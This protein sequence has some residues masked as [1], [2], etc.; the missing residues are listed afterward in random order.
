MRRASLG[1]GGGAAGGFARPSPIHDYLYHGPRGAITPTG[2]LVL[3]TAP[4]RER[5]FED[6]AEPP[7]AGYPHALLA[8]GRAASATSMM[9]GMGGMGGGMALNQLLIVM[10]GIDDPPLRKRFSDEPRQHAA[11]RALHRPAARRQGAPAAASRRSPPTRRST[12][13]APATS[14]SRRSTRRSRARAAWAGTSASARRSRTT[15]RT[16]SSFYLDKVSHEPDLDT[17]RRRDELARITGGYSPGDDRAGLLDGAHV[18]PPR[19]ARALRLGRH[20]RGHDDGRDGHRGRRRVRRAR[21]RGR[22][23]STRRATPPPATST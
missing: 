19:R 14:R 10:D 15:A 16:S 13:S 4:W 9:P 5:Q 3:E 6:R 1:A 22:P 2:D 18:R 21:R 17:D 7:R 11:R 20:R 23:R 12:S 8:A